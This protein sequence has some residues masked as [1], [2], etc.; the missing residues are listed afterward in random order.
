MKTLKLLSFKIVIILS[1]VIAFTLGA[2][3]QSGN[4]IMN[5]SITTTWT[6]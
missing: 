3:G 4:V 1:I 2:C 6:V 5:R